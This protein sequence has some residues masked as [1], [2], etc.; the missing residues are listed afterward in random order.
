MNRE[1]LENLAWKVVSTCDD[2][3]Q[4]MSWAMEA[5]VKRYETD[6]QALSEDLENYNN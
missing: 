5:L 3:D 1:S 4:L 6:P 2:T